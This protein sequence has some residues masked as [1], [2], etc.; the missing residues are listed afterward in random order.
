MIIAMTGSFAVWAMVASA[1]ATATGAAVSAYSSHQQGK[2]Q[3]Q[4]AEA[5][6]AENAYQ[7]KLEN[8]RAGIAQLQ[9]EQ[10]AEKR[11]RIMAADIGSLYAGYAGNGLLVDGGKKDT[12]GS[13]LSTTINEGIADISTIKDNAALD[14]WTHQANAKSLLASAGNNRIYGKNMQRAG[15]ISA[16]GSLAT[17]TGS[18]LRN[19]LSDY[20]HLSR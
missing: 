1:I 10:E 7:A 18:L 3:R 11:S 2:A 4:A 19:G 6:A 9:G 12:L 17:G 5:Q 20:D 13:V 14:V 16:L 8:E 15:N